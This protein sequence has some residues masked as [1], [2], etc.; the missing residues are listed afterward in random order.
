MDKPKIKTLVELTNAG[1][2]YESVRDE[3]RRNLALRIKH[4]ETLFPGIIGY[5]NTVLP[6]LQNAILSKHSI[7]LLGLRGQ[8]KTR[9][10]SKLTNFLDEWSPAI[11]GS[12]LNCHPLKP[13]CATS[14]RLISEHGDETEITW[15]HRSE[16][17]HEKL[18]TPDVTIADL[19]GD[20]DPI[21]A[22]RE[23]R[24]LTDEEVISYGI[25]PRSCRGIFTV[26]ELPDLQARIQVGLLNILEENELQ[27]RGFPVRIPI[28]IVLVF[29]ANPEDYTNRGNIITPLKD[30]IDSQII[31]HYPQSLQDSIAITNQEAW[32]QRQGVSIKMP[33]FFREI[34]EL[35]AIVA[36]DSEYIDKSSGVSARLTIA[37]AENVISNIERR[38]LLNNTTST[39]PRISDVY[40]AISAITGKVELAYEGEQEGLTHVA[41][42]LIGHAVKQTFRNYFPRIEKADNQ[43]VA[44]D[45]NFGEI[46]SYFSD[47]S[48]IELSDEITPEKYYATLSEIMNLEKTA[49][50]FL[51]LNSEEETALGMEFILEGLYQEN[52]IAK[53]YLSDVYKY[54]DLMATLLG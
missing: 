30:R 32:I 38:N 52:L 41:I 20:L 51:T 22:A 49:K 29:T 34:V 14:K 28:D 13:T 2:K 39:T 36:R 23:K 19:I 10:S 4:K 40:A 43:P 16:R 26:N 5:D 15:Q 31:T 54:S 17:Y 25:I 3:L 11:K 18:A 45:P 46:L 47:T 33:D 12:P 24:D 37:L 8:A 53:S 6:A 1:Y 35:V 27:I 44:A 7:I 21:K 42:N 50:K 9:I 48:G